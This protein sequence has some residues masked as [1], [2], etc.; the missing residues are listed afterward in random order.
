MTL[1]AARIN[2]SADIEMR[3]QR[4]LAAIA[5]AKEYDA[6]QPKGRGS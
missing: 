3:A 5:A 6:D 4:S 2:P 1:K